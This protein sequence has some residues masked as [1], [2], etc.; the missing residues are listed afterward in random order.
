MEEERKKDSNLVH[1][2]YTETL[3]SAINT[4]NVKCHAFS[5]L[6]SKYQY[7]HD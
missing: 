3:F 4:M 1:S 2:Y 6:L 5:S 7:C